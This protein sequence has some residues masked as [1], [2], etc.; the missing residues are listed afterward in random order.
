MMHL[1]SNNSQMEP[2]LMLIWY[3]QSFYESKSRIGYNFQFGYLLVKLSV[4]A[5]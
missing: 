1:Y 2:L 3:I 4:T 5:I